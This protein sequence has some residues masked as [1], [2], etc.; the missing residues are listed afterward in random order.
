MVDPR[1]SL[2]IK[3]QGKSPG[4]NLELETVNIV[5]AITSVDTAQHMAKIVKYAQKRITLLKSVI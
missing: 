2:K 4:L 3:T 5:V 1:K